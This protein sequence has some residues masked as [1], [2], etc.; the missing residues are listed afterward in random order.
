MQL[1]AIHAGRHHPLQREQMIALVFSRQPDDQMAAHL[2]PALPGPLRGLLIAAEIMAAVDAFERFIVRRLQPQLQPHFITLLAIPRQQIHAAGGTQSGRVPT[3][4][5]T[6]SL[7]A[8]ACRYIDA[9][10]STSA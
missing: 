2:Q 9:S 6:I 4:R 3:H 5:P 7:C 10:S 8:N 1:D